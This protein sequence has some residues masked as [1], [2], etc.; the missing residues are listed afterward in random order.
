MKRRF[1]LLYLWFHCKW[2][3]GDVFVRYGFAPSHYIQ[4][5]AEQDYCWTCRKGLK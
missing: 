1:K 4:R 3:N 5:T 2:A